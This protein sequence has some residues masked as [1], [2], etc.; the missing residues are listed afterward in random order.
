MADKARFYRFDLCDGHGCETRIITAQSKA[1]AENVIAASGS[2][3]QKAQNVKYLGWCNVR[4]QPD[5]ME[6]G[7]AFV[8]N[9]EDNNVTINRTIP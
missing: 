6:D 2:P 4:P 5:D 8:A 7:V 9:V 1:D 3:F